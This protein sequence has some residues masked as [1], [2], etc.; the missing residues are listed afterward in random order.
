MTQT[1]DWGACAGVPGK[2]GKSETLSYGNNHKREP[3]FISF[4][5]VGLTVY[6]SL[7]H[8]RKKVFG[9]ERVLSQFSELEQKSFSLAS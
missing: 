9:V 3:Q 2:S 5:M 1:E 7:S 6:E 8:Q 4:P